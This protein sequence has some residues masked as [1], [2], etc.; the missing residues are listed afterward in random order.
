MGNGQLS[1]IFLMKIRALRLNDARC[2][3]GHGQTTHS[4]WSFHA[5]S[6]FIQKTVLYGEYFKV[7]EESV[8]CT[9]ISPKGIL[10]SV[11]DPQHSYVY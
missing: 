5:V 7:L 1:I 2:I 3:R 9:K 4:G 10:T 6:P 8:D 11:R